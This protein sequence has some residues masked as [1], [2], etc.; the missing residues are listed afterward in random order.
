MASVRQICVGQ[1]RVQTAGGDKQ[2]GVQ[3]A[4]A[5]DM[6]AGVQPTHGGDGDGHAGEQAGTQVPKQLAQVAKQLA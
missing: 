5:G 3:P 6:Q 4:G 2:A 1:K